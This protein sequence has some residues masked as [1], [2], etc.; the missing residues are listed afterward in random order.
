MSVMALLGALYAGSKNT[1][2]I[3]PPADKNK[4]VI[5][6]FQLPRMRSALS[7]KQKDVFLDREYIL[8]GKR[9]KKTKI[10]I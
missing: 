6:K 9:N 3:D 4:E 10:G 5:L 8:E 1:L 2:C 7:N